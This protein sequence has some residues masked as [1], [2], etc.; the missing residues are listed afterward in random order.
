MSYRIKEQ[1]S[2]PLNNTILNCP[3][4]LLHGVFSKNIVLVFSLYRSLSTGTLCVWLEIIICGIKRTRIWVLILSRLFQHP[5]L[6]WVIHQFLCFCGRDS[7][8]WIFNCMVGWEWG[9]MEPSSPLLFKDQ[10]YSNIYSTQEIYCKYD[11]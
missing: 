11:I 1:Y 10:L 4:P 3:G 6:K 7:S 8:A 2:W 5:A 9:C